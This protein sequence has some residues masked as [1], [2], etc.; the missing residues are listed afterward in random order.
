LIPASHTIC[1][2][3][4]FRSD[5]MTS[6]KS[7][8]IYK[9][10][11]G[12]HLNFVS[13]NHTDHGSVHDWY[14]QGLGI[15][16]ACVEKD[17]KVIL[18]GASMGLWLSLLIGNQRK[19]TG[20]VGVGGGINFTERWLDQ[21]PKEKRNDPSYRW[22]RPSEYTKEGYYE[23]PVSFLI[24]SRPALLSS[25]DLKGCRVRLLHGSDDQDV[26]FERSVALCEHLRALNVDVSL[27]EIKGGD[28]RLSSCDHL[29]IIINKIQSLVIYNSLFLIFILQ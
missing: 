2:I 12:Q 27:D 26:L 13:W 29:D 15:M 16:D 6:K 17:Q 8:A 14:E 19:V 25:V 23:I 1:F 22:R 28:H 10:C 21:V 18:V 20:I 11:V 3:P 7:V 9:Y 5:A 4:G 24:E